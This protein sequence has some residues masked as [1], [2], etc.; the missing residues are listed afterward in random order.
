MS[1]AERITWRAQIASLGRTSA[2]D[3]SPPWVVLDGAHTPASAQALVATLA[4]VF[5]QEPLALVVSMAE[6]KDH[7]GILAALRQAAP[8]AVIFTSVAIAGAQTR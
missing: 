2:Q 1:A 7:R 5:P 3:E 8:K 4:E 6:D